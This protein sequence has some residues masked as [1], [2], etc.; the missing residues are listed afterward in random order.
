MDQSKL[1]SRYRVPTCCLV[2][3]VLAA[4]L[5]TGIIFFISGGKMRVIALLAD[6]KAKGEP[7]RSVDLEPPGVPDA[8]N[9]FLYYERA[10]TMMVKAPQSVDDAVKRMREVP[11]SA[12]KKA[13]VDLLR[14][15][16][17]QN[18]AA[19]QVVHQGTLCKGYKSRVT[20]K[21]PVKALYPNLAKS[22]DLA[23]ELRYK[24]QVDI[25]DGRVDEAVNACGDIL[26]M[27]NHVASEST[28][29]AYLVGVACR[30]MAYVPLEYA[31]GATNDESTLRHIMS[32]LESTPPLK[33]RPAMIGERANGV[34]IFENLRKGKFS[35]A[36][37]N[38]Q[39]GNTNS[40]KI[41]PPGWLFYYDEAAYVKAMGERIELSDKPY[42]AVQKRL[43]ELD[44]Q[45]DAGP[46]YAP[47]SR[48]LMPV[49]SRAH[50]AGCKTDMQAAVLRM[51]AAIKLYR[52]KHGQY[53][54]S[55]SDLQPGIV[56]T[57]PIDGFTGKPLIYKLKGKGFVVYSVGDNQVDDGGVKP[58]PNKPG[59]GDIVYE[60][61]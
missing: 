11:V 10:A 55:L 33:I 18:A 7:V 39:P 54:K 36:D 31:I 3:I 30:A 6:V 32:L 20:W 44:V 51:A 60:E 61:K 8:D 47:I 12:W 21:D 53:P 48:I 19:L 14:A 37:L 2:F 43:N 1:R 57:I 22:R 38:G 16:V 9:A 59:G 35:I 45:A 25:Y 24:A 15:H 28:L 23:R 41:R 5:F 13:D 50:A 58:N 34:T 40:P 4:I 26:R 49:F 56:K 29:I 17:K 42:Y 27:S 46:V 52:I